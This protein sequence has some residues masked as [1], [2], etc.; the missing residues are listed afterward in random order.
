VSE[1]NIGAKLAEGTPAGVP[2]RTRALGLLLCAAALLA[3]AGCA[4][5]GTAGQRHPAVLVTEG[6][7]RPPEIP[8]DFVGLSYEKSSLSLP[9]F[10]ADNAAMVTLFRRLGPGVLRIGGNSVD[11]TLWD[12]TGPGLQHGLV[13]PADVSRLAR[14]LRVAGWRIIYGLNLGTAAPRAVAEEAAAARAAF[15]GLL[16]AFEIGNEPDLYHSNGLRPRDYSYNDFL[17]E[18]ESDARSVSRRVPDASFAGPATARDF[19]G[20][21]LPFSRDARDQISLLTHHYYRANGEL[22]TSTIDLMLSPD[23]RLGELLGELA[24]AARA[25]DILLGFRLGEA[26]SFFNGG[27]PGVSDSFASA[28]WVIDFLFRCASAGASGVNLHGGGDGPGYTPIADNGASVQD[29][30][31]AYYG[32]LLF[33]MAARGSMAGVAVKGTDSSV[34]AWAVFGRDHSLRVIL[35]NAGEPA[36]TPV[37]V[38]VPSS[39]RAV[40]L[41]RLE[42]TSLAAEKGTLLGGAPIRPDG[43]WE[44]VEEQ[45]VVQKGRITVT[46]K[47]PEAIL[48]V[49][50]P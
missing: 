6:Q 5:L 35:V 47:G 8:P 3:F 25:G 39:Y 22:P 34:S 16:V 48:A 24:D 42:N 4:H 27:A 15:G 43:T 33:S 30:R 49:F 45:A 50:R 36:G 28:L 41:L 13:A 1:K 10:S 9:L 44:G 29:V 7:G 18:W 14:F 21:T 19:R 11:R 26:S 46:L 40:S 37:D 32:M 38:E 12:P 20:Y 31:P 17:T 2:M 23:P